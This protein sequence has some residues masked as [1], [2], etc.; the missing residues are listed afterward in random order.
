MYCVIQEIETKKENKYGAYRELEAY[1]YEWSSSY[2]HRYTGERFN[3]SIKKA[4]KISIHNSYRERGE[5]KKKQ[6]VMC[7]MGY[8]DLAANGG[9]IGDWCNLKKKSELI[10]IDEEELYNIISIKLEPLRDRLEKEFQQTEEYKIEAE[11]R[12]IINLHIANKIEFE[13][14]YGKDTY[15]KYYDVFGVLRESEKLEE[16]KKQHEAA[17]EYQRSYRENFNSN[18]DNYSNSSYQNNYCSN[19]KEEDK[20]KYKEMYKTL[21]K[22]YHPDKIKDDGEMM[23]LVNQLKEEWK[24]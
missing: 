8:Y 3:R 16:L 1:R 22:V 9:Y 18:H 19:H 15:D 6:W 10:G 21:A 23:K 14:E 4:Y 7:T 13:E 20:K 24:L 5:V 2:S 12:M 17:K 11:H